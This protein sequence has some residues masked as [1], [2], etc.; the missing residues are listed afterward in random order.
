MKF[1]LKDLMWSVTLACVGLGIIV[2]LQKAT[3]DWRENDFFESIA[4]Y[5]TLST[6]PIFGAAIGK[7]FHRVRIGAWVGVYLSALMVLMRPAIN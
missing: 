4:L 3:F 5:L 2:F 7:L 6:P 1:S